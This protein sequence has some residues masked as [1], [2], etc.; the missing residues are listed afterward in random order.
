MIKVGANRV[1][2]REIE[3]VIAEV[4]GVAEVCVAGVPD[5][6]L[7]EAVEAFVVVSPG[8]DV[9]P[10]RVLA[11]CREYLALYKVP[12]GVHFR[13]A[14]PRGAAERFCVANWCVLSERLVP[15]FPGLSGGAP[16]DRG[17]ALVA[18]EPMLCLGTSSRCRRCTRSLWTRR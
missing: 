10:E 3:D 2:P 14:L 7:G 18:G 1:S 16:G 8:A 11:H 13:D 6:L 15:A 17:L 9:S 5:E 12:R 4:A